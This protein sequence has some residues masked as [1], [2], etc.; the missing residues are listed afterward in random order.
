MK[1]SA[2]DFTI[3]SKG[4]K[5]FNQVSGTALPHIILN[6][7]DES[8]SII[9]K[10]YISTVT[11]P[12]V[13]D[14]TEESTSTPFFVISSEIKEFSFSEYF[15]ISSLILTGTPGTVVTILLTSTSIQSTS[16]DSYVF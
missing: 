10:S 16:S 5:I 7:V 13:L 14:A 4:I 8:G 3:T 6:L 1:S 9:D 15:N 11:T 2:Y 12:I